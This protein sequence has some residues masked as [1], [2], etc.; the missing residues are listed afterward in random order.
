MLANQILS[1]RLSPNASRISVRLWVEADA[2]ELRDNWVSIC[3]TLSCS[4]RER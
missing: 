3:M 2:T 4:I 1:A